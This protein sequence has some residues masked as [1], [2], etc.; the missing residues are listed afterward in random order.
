MTTT[1]NRPTDEE[2]LAD[3]AAPLD[4][5]LIDAALGTARRFAPDAS[6]VKFVASRRA[7]S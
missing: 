5:L 6:T 2:E 7:V 1:P 4:A 3:R